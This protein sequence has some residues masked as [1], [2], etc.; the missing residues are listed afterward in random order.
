MRLSETAAPE[1]IQTAYTREVAD[2]AILYAGM[3]YADLAHMVVLIEAGVAPRAAGGQLL[4]ALLA[5]HP[6]PP[7]DFAR[8]P[9]VG[10]VYSNREAHLAMHTPYV[11]YLAAGRARREA[12]T[13]AY[14]RAVRAR[15]LQLAGALI[16]CAHAAADLAAQHRATLFPDYTYLQTAQPTSFG[17]YILTF[18]YPVLRD[19]E[20]LRAAYARTNLSPAGSGSV[21]GSRLPLDRERLARLLGFEG[22]IHHTRDAMWQPDGPIEIL[23]LL[24]AALTNLDRLAEDLQ[25]FTTQEFRLLEL[26]DRHARTSKIMPQKKNPYALTYVRGVAGEILG[27]LAAMAA[28]GKTPSGQPDNRIFAH[29]GVPRALDQTVGAVRLMAGVLRGLRLDETRAAERATAGFAGATDLAE[30]IMLATGIDYRAAHTI[31][32]RLA[33][34]TPAPAEI[35]PADVAAAA[36][37]VVGRRLELSTDQLAQALDANRIVATRTGVGG[38]AE[39]AVDVMLAELRA[40]LQEHSAWCAD[41]EMRL[42]QANTTLQVEAA[43]LAIAPRQPPASPSG[44]DRPKTMGDLLRDDDD[45]A[46][47][48]GGKTLG[49]L[50]NEPPGWPFGR[51]DW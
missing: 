32:A 9:A 15:L 16:D 10:D 6:E 14:R 7:L 5:I 13:I 42:E 47:R 20:R 18:A 39:T 45:D 8:D 4:H 27:V 40:A 3:S 24:S 34:D 17:H 46:G 43:A 19:L 50:L 33:R 12:I 21:N 30:V 28:I 11:G 26:A 38:A 23:A 29:G 48:P 1:L 2:T 37:A 49:D 41:C 25:I 44:T 22:V 36:E 51:R 35:T 31:V